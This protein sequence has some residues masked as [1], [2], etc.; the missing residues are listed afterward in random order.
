MRTRTYART[1][2]HS[3]THPPTQAS[4]LLGNRE[5]AILALLSMSDH[6]FFTWQTLL[7]TTVVCFTLM[8]ITYGTVR[9]NVSSYV[10]T[11]LSLSL[12]LNLSLN[13]SL[14]LTLSRSLSLS[15][16]RSLSLSLSR[17]LS[18]TLRVVPLVVVLALLIG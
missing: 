12:S 10:H 13:L 3:L 5:E 9:Q 2:T 14:S 1:Y 6:H 8:S 17:S 11:R 4:I 18:L 15:L 7:V 16:S